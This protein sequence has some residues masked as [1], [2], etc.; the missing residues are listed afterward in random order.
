M[1]L[2]IWVAGIEWRVMRAT[3]PQTGNT[4]GLATRPSWLDPSHPCRKAEVI[5]EPFLTA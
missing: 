3:S 2:G 1:N 5:S 4:W